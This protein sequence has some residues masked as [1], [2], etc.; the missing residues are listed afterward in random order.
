MSLERMGL[1]GVLSMDVGS[2]VSAMG[3]AGHASQALAAAVQGV[4]PAAD[5]AGTAVTGMGQKALRGARETQSAADQVSTAISK[6]GG[7][8]TGV[9]VAFAPLTA[10]FGLGFSQA[11]AFEKQM[12]AVGAVS[13]GTAAEMA[14]LETQAKHLGATTTFTATQAAEGME[15]LSRAG[16]TTKEIGEG[17]AGV[18]NAAAAD[19]ID[20]ATSADIVSRVIKGMNLSFSESNRVADVLALASARTNTDMVGLGESFKYAAA[21]SRVMKI[22]LETTASLLGLAADAGLRGSIGGTSFAAMLNK[23]AAP[24]EKANSWLQANTIQF[25]KMADGGLDIVSVIKQVNM[26]ME[27]ETDIVKKAAIANELF[28]DRG[29]KAFN[30]FSAAIDTGKIDSL[31]KELQGAEGTAAMMAQKRLDNFDGAMKLLTSAWE[32]FN[33]ETMSAFLDPFADNIKFITTG[34]SNVN[35]VLAELNGVGTMTNEEMVV[36]YGETWVNIAFGIADGFRWMMTTMGEVKAELLDGLSYFTDGATPDMIRSITKIVVITAMIGAALA[37]VLLGFGAAALLITTAVI[38]AV[39]GVVT[40]VEGVA[41]AMSSWGAPLLLAFALFRNEGESVGDTLMRAFG[42]VRDLIAWITENVVMPFATSFLT[43]VIPYVSEAVRHI[44]SFFGTVREYV[45]QVLGG[46]IQGFQ[47]LRPFFS[48][49]FS[50]LGNI[51]GTFVEY[52]IMGFRAILNAVQPILQ[53]VKEVALFMIEYVVNSIL[54]TVKAMVKLADAIGKS[55]WVPAGFREFAKQGR[56]S[57]DNMLASTTFNQIGIE[58]PTV[59]PNNLNAASTAALA[60]AATDKEAGKSKSP[61]VDVNVNLEDKRQLDIHACTTITGRSTSKRYTSAT[62]SRRRHGS[63]GRLPSK[64]PCRS[65]DLEVSDAY[66]RGRS[67]HSPY[68]SGQRSWS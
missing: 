50:L 33:I 68:D 26:A 45:A 48:G 57:I 7:V 25:N 34:I 38:P 37:P 40:V 63:V 41:L 39:S 17:I 1:G 16:A 56:F 3:S 54:D 31:L 65:A 27:A 43:H 9:G 20:L 18:L 6:L 35:A 61:P 19:S 23:L 36:K 8:A 2:A 28:G 15:N 24:S 58:S 13:L 53:V 46:I 32:G 10:V 59:A 55:D 42:G 14:I 66:H 29:Q 21:A 64:A 4:S 67:R 47:F 51:I 12:S 5:R 22:D 62:A 11:V 60:K 44:T 52:A 49:L 30:A